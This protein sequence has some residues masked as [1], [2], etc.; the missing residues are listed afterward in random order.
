MNIQEKYAENVRNAQ[1]RELSEQEAHE[2]GGGWRRA[3]TVAS[4][5]TLPNGK[6]NPGGRA[7]CYMWTKPGAEGNHR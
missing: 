7:L 5:A 3:N 1:M 6:D 2:V 4:V